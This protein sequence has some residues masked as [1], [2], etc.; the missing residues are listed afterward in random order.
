MN[1][2]TKSVEYLNR[3]KKHMPLGV[4]DSY[5][6]WGEEETVTVDHMEDCRFVDVD[7][8]EF[9]DFSLAY[10]PIILG[11]RDN[12]VDSA[13]INTIQ[14]K[15]SMVGF[16]TTGE[17]DVAELIKA[18]CPQIEKLRFAN[19]GTEA[20]FGAVRT[21]RGYTGKNMVVIVEGGFHG[22]YDE[23][24]WKPDV[25]K[26]GKWK[27]KQIQELFLSGLVFQNSLRN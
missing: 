25:E 12:R 7:G 17:S 13:V 23:M 6:Y 24:M 27:K 2:H 18:M 9:I 5:R 1:K 14:N 15:G 19:S 26:T 4:A 16:S 22:L 10:G 21:A 3:A 20:V 8:N 11:Y